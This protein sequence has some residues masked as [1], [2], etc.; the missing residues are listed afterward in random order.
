MVR[1]LTIFLLV[2][3]WSSCS[4]EKQN[5][6]VT[7]DSKGWQI[8]YSNDDEG[9]ALSGDIDNLKKAVRRGCEIRVGWGQYSEYK[10]DGLTGVFAVEHTA[11]AQFLTINKGHV[12][13]QLSRIMGQAPSRE[14]NH[15]NLVKTHYWHSVLGT[16]GEMTQVYLDHSDVNKSDEFSDNIK[17]I[18]YINKNDCSY[19][20]NKN[21]VLY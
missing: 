8:I 14:R 9:N 17:V 4:K 15:I 19:E 16:T 12:Y 6:K 18:W 1:N 21:Q 11:D 7:N 10:K 20:K 13:A 5:K 2:V 3:L